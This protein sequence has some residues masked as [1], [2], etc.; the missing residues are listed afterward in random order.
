ML[1]SLSLWVRPAGRRE[2][3]TRKTEN[4][5]ACFTKRERPATP[6]VW[7]ARALQH[8][9]RALGSHS[10]IAVSSPPAG[11]AYSAAA[12]GR[13]QSGE[14]KM[15]S[16]RS[17]RPQQPDVTLNHLALYRCGLETEQFGSHFPRHSDGAVSRLLGRRSRGLKNPTGSPPTKRSISTGDPGARGT[18]CH[19]QSVGE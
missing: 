11:R 7:P 9:D 15:P 1:L 17:V 16:P 3:P 10:C 6:H 19:G 13:T 14:L 18:W 4:T 8:T 12:A 5:E 2:E